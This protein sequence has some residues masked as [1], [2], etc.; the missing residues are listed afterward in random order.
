MDMQFLSQ[1]FLI[2]VAVEVIFLLFLLVTGKGDQSRLMRGRLALLDWALMFLGVGFLLV[3]GQA[4]VALTALD[5]GRFSEVVM[6][7]V[8]ITLVFIGTAIAT[9]LFIFVGVLRE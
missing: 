8:F 3:Q 4:N 5:A 9:G 6:Q 7:F 1:I 2:I